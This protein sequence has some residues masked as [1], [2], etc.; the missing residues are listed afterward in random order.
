VWPYDNTSG[1]QRY[2]EVAHTRGLVPNWT[3]V[4]ILGEVPIEPDGS[5]HFQVPADTAVYFQLLDEN[6]M[7]LRRMRSFISFQSGERR[8]CTGCHETRE[9]AP[10]AAQKFPRAL[11]RDPS[12]PMPPAWGQQPLSFLRDVQ[13]IFDRHCVACHGGLKP[14]GGLDFCGG[15]TRREV[16]PAFAANRAYD[17]IR[18]RG[19][20]AISNIHDDARV[21]APL[22]FGSHRSELVRV[23]REGACGKRATLSAQEWQRLV[24]W[25]DANAPYHDAFINKRAGAM[26]YDLPADEKLIAAVA[27]VHTR[28]CNQCHTAGEVTQSHWIDVHDPRRSLFLSAPLARSAG[29]SGKCGQPIYQNTDDADYRAVLDLVRAAA[30]RAWQSPRRDLAALPP[31]AFP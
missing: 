7:E 27:A 16:I 31:P 29:G 26:P 11:L 30:R 19:L 5:A 15:L 18:S 9:E 8:G 10:R 21:T 24:T 6:H 20:V 4:R 3:P 13:P 14:A 28:R 1:G 22:A 12:I 25:I 23:L 17:T 2:H